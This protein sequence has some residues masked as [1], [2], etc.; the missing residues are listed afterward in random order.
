MDDLLDW[1]NFLPSTG[2]ML[3]TV[4]ALLPDAFEEKLKFAER[5]LHFFFGS[6]Q[7]I[8]IMT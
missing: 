5:A 7:R 4:F 3:K 1:K 8:Y 6:A 2:A